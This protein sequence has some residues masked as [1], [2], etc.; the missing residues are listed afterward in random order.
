MIID[1]RER[2]AG[3]IARANN[4]PESQWI[5]WANEAEFVLAELGLTQAEPVAKKCIYPDCNCPFDHPGT[6]GWCARGLATKAAPQP[7]ASVERYGDGVLVHWPDGTT[8]QYVE[9]GDCVTGKLQPRQQASEEDFERMCEAMDFYAEH[10]GALYGEQT[11]AAK[12]RIRAALAV[13]KEKELG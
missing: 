11:I 7:Q 8:A 13:V 2:V 5:R 6:K 4:A 9:V 3:A 10:E 12:D 1:L